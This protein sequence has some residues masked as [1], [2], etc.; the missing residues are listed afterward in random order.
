MV[1]SRFGQMV[2][3]TCKFR[4]GIAF[5]IRVSFIY[6][7]TSVRPE[8]GIKYGLIWR[9]WTRGLEYSVRKNKTTFSDAWLLPEIFRWNDPKSRVPFTFQP[10]FPDNFA[11]GKRPTAGLS[12]R[13]AFLLCESAESFALATFKELHFPI[14]IW[15][16]AEWVDEWKQTWQ[17]RTTSH[18]SYVLNMDRRVTWNR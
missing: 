17:P 4:P 15:Y 16:Y 12:A 14:A 9:N 7:I 8:T 13:L 2:R 6:R 18:E 3:K 5:A 11:N 1:S 10:D